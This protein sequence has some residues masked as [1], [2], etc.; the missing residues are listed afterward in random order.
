MTKQRS[1][2]K[3]FDKR[4]GSAGGG[5]A[6]VYFVKEK[7]GNGHYALKELRLQRSK[8]GKE[9]LKSQEMKQRF[10]NEIDI[11]TKYAEN[12]NGIIPIIKVCKKDYWYTMPIAEPIMHY[13][14]GKGI[15][16]IIVGVIQLA[17]T[18]ELLHSDGVAHRDIKPANIYYLKDSFALGDFGL[19]DF[20]ENF[21]DYTKEDR[22]LGA[23][24]TI[25]PEMKRNPKE[26]DGTKADVFSLAKTMWMM[27]T[28]NERGFDGVYNFLD[29]SHSL[30]FCKEYEKIHLVELDELLQDATA[31]DPDMR[32]TIREM[33]ARL[34]NWLQI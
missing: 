15:E 5:N 28:K 16:E 22:G 19:V 20:P 13:I 25:A 7:N 4:E 34:E 12:S 21:N 31:N 9:S 8:H 10:I 26:A 24:F 14:E 23:I 3:D 11:A 2:H 32:P 6:N 30:R 1:W 29:E 17:E 27:L 33:K 18:L